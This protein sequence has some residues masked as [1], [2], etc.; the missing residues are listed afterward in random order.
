MLGVQA[1]F[2]NQTHPGKNAGSE[3]SSSRPWADRLRPERWDEF[4]GH[5]QHVNEVKR[6]AR[7][8]RLPCL[9]LEGPPGTG[10]STFARLLKVEFEGEWVAMNGAGFSAAELRSCLAD[11]MASRSVYLLLDEIHRLSKTQQDT[12]LEP[13]ESGRLIL[14]ATTTESCVHVLSRAILSRVRVLKFTGLQRE[15]LSKILDRAV[16]SLLPGS[17]QAIF[18]REAQDRLM[19]LSGGDARI[20]LGSLTEI[21]ALQQVEQRHVTLSDV[22]KVMEQ[23]GRDGLGLTQFY[24]LL[25]VYIKAMRA[26]EVDKAL[27]S[28]KKML[29]AGVDPRVVARRILIFASEDVGNAD[30]QA[31]PLA[32]AAAQSANSVGM[33]EVAIIL[34]QVTIYL[35]RAPKSR[36][37]YECYKNLK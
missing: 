23:V 6:W 1:D 32:S 27:V 33:P 20:M 3:H 22:E 35:S 10:K 36:E 7:Q 5:S 8:G 37:A 18:G 29:S 12:L 28:L 19:E 31:L 9:V 25:S 21:L 2:F 34:S 17:S 16:E 24:D 14:V 30:P 11:K 15:A 26:G 13:L 4:H